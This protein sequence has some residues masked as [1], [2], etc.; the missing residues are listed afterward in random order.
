MLYRGL[1]A[2]RLLDDDDQLETYIADVGFVL[3]ALFNGFIIVA[4]IDLGVGWLAP[5]GAVAAI[6]VGSRLLDRVKRDVRDEVA[7]S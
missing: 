1:R 2:R 6:V 7:G 3:V 4:L 5:I